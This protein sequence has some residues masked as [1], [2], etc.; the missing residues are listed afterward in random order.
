[1]SLRTAATASPKRLA[2]KFQATPPFAFIYI[3]RMIYVQ[4][5]PFRGGR[6]RTI[7][8]YVTELVEGA[9]GGCRAGPQVWTR[10]TGADAVY[11]NN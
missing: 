8:L 10:S 7:V 2:S 1:M 6:C 9:V 11:V 4:Q 3:H 5:S